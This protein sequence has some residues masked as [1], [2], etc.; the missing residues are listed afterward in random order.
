MTQSHFSDKAM[1]A[2]RFVEYIQN[3][4]NDRFHD[5]MKKTMLK[6]LAGYDEVYISC[7][8]RVVLLRHPRQY[9]T[10]PGIAE[11]EQY[12]IEALG[13]YKVTKQDLGLL[14]LEPNTDNSTVSTLSEAEREE[15]RAMISE[16]F[17]DK[18]ALAGCLAQIVKAS[19]KQ[20]VGNAL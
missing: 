17:A 2:E 18:P 20:G 1:K 19:E 14:A 11:L 15:M 12:A 3:C 4:F 7:L 10:A 8:A 5:D 6:Y 13:D 9:K 16:K